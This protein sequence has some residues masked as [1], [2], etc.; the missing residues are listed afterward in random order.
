VS[1]IPY[2]DVD[3]AVK[4]ANDRAT[5]GGGISSSTS[6]SGR[7]GSASAPACLDQQR[8]PPHDRRAFGGFKASGIGR[9]GGKWGSRSTREIQQITWKA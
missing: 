1:V 9:E 6:A 7:V 2:K 8:P 4:I 3:E 5:L